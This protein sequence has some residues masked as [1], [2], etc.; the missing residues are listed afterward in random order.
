MVGN[1]Q[2][3]VQ[4][5]Q[6]EWFEQWSMLEDRE[7]FLFKDWIQPLVLEDFRGKDVLDAGCG[8]GQHTGFVA[9]IA[10]HVTAVD[11]NAVS[12][13]QQRNKDVRN[14]TYV[15]ADIA[16]MDLGRKFDI[17]MS[18]GVVH[19]TDSPEATIHNLR[20]HLKPGG[21][22]IVWVYSEEGNALVRYGVEPIRKVFL[23]FL[24]R[25]WLLQLSRVIAACMVLPIYSIY[26]LPVKFLPYYAYFQNWRRL[27]FTR[28][29]LNVFD[30]LNAPQVDFISKKR[31]DT[32]L[33]GLKDP[34]VLPYAGVSFSLSGMQP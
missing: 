8:S 9:P 28:N 33:L 32:L 4:K 22:L 19:H 27:S 15:Q 21:R 30:K 20:R 12:I 5:Q 11:L 16:T 14:V 6:S 3:V 7:L 1:A 17:V 10:R 25:S 34:K 23:R 2:G 31:A 13:A 18:I 26:L 24:P 29:V